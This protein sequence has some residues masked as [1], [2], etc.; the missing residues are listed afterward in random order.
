MTDHDWIGLVP[1]SQ[2]EAILL[3]HAPALVSA[4]QPPYKGG[5]RIVLDWGKVRH[6]DVLEPAW[7]PAVW[8]TI[9]RT[10]HDHGHYVSEYSIPERPPAY[11]RRGSGTTPDRLASIDKEVEV[12]AVN[13]R[14][15]DVAANTLTQ[16]RARLAAR[17]ESQG[18]R[19]EQGS[20]AT[21]RRMVEVMRHT[22]AK[23]D[24][25]DERAA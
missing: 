6:P 13:V 19:A 20:P 3:G 17:L 8:V 4:E 7:Y 10:H 25:L 15:D 16:A 24:E 11:L 12:E 2:R 5:D 9:L 23:L 1:V 14:P 18:R 21:A 22:R